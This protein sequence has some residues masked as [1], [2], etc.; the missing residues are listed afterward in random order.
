MRT[1][2]LTLLI[3][4]LG[5][6]ISLMSVAVAMMV[7]DLIEKVRNMNHKEKN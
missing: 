5:L 2:L 3:A 1:L 6:A 4:F 7:G